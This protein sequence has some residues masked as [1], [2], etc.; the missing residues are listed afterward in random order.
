MKLLLLFFTLLFV[1]FPLDNTSAM[2]DTHIYRGRY[3]NSSDI[4]LTFGGLMPVPVML[5]ALI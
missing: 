4:L 5:M 1:D 3:T 2:A